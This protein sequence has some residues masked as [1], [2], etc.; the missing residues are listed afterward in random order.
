MNLRNMAP[1]HVRQRRPQP[2]PR[3]VP[4]E[5]VALKF[6]QTQDEVMRQHDELLPSIAAE[7]RHIIGEGG[8][9]QVPPLIEPMR[10]APV[11]QLQRPS[12]G[13]VVA[14]IVAG[15]WTLSILAVYFIGLAR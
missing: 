15:V 6:A 3:P 13:R 2:Q 4:N 11:P 5:L 14:A 12:K 8:A 9:V 7:H 1:W 10:G